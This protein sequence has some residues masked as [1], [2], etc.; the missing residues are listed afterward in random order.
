MASTVS[1][2]SGNGDE[3]NIAHFLPRHRSR[4][5]AGLDHTLT[6]DTI[7][8]LGNWHANQAKQTQIDHTYFL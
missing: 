5:V 1:G 3:V 6:L 4:L 7:I 2:G 8:D